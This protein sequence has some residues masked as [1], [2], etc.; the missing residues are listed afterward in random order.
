MSLSDIMSILAILVS[1]FSFYISFKRWKDDNRPIVITKVNVVKEGNIS[2][3]FNMI[4]ENTGNR[5]AINVQLSVNQKEL[6]EIL[7]AAKDHPLRKAVEK[8][9]SSEASI[10]ILSNGQTVENSFGIISIHKNE[11]TWRPDSKLNVQVSYQD[12]NGRSYHNTIP[13]FITGAPGFAGSCWQEP[14]N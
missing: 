13:V 7:I 12:L 3:A 11:T 1:L 4:V 8:C 6:N 5:P 10:S 2:A 14:N 9:F